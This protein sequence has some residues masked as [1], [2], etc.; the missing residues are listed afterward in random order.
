MGT[1]GSGQATFD[2]A[3]TSFTLTGT[4]DSIVGD[5]SGAATLTFQNSASFG[6]SAG[7]TARRLI[8]GNQSTATGTITATG[9]GTTA[10]TTATLD[11]GHSGTGNLNV[12]AGAQWNHTGDLTTGS[13][14]GSH[15]NVLVDGA[16]SLLAISGNAYIGGT[17]SG[18]G[19]SALLTLSNGG[20][21]TANTLTTY[22]TGSVHIDQTSTLTANV[23]NNG[24]VRDD[25]LLIGNVVNNGALGG[26]GTITG[27]LTLNGGSFTSTGAGPIGTLTAG[28]TNWFG[29]AHFLLN[30]DSALGTAGQSNG[31][32]LLNI[33][34]GLAL[35][36][37]PSS[38]P[39]SLISVLSNGTQGNLSDFDPMQ[40]YAW[41]FATA[42]GGITGFSAN[43]FQVISSGFQGGT[44]PGSR[45]HVIEVGN[46][47]E[48]TYTAPVPEPGTL[49]LAAAG[50]I[51]LL[52]FGWR[53]RRPPR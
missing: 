25:G 11:I 52:F 51:T 34:G 1:G 28:A 22:G 44:L 41:T 9:S 14:S 17:A 47:L 3:G 50:A 38:I 21:L 30:I 49:V 16:G 15:G 13:A 43:G 18:A 35:H 19:G 26:V 36:T 2:G 5:S 12:L 37:S 6:D 24:G 29:N 48:L 8:V 53:K 32:D 4:G 40:N 33:T 23:V 42:L 20:S 46:S 10:T 39:I 45:F 7:G 31:W 27:T